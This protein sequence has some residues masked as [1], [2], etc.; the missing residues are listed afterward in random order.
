MLTS[1]NKSMLEQGLP[2]ME[3]KIEDIGAEVRDLNSLPGANPENCKWRIRGAK[4]KLCRLE[5]LI[6]IPGEDLRFRFNWIRTIR[7]YQL[8]RNADRMFLLRPA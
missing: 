2:F 6:F 8:L 7:L 3:A 4:T 5:A 1:T